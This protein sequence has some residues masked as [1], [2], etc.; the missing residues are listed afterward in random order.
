MRRLHPYAKKTVL[1]VSSSSGV[2]ILPFA[3]MD[4]RTETAGVRTR[5]D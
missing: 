2:A 5:V 1:L 3:A 4:G